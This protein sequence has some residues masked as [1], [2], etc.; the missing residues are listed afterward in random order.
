[1]SNTAPELSSDEQRAL[2]VRAELPEAEPIWGEVARVYEAFDGAWIVSAHRTGTYRTSSALRTSI[3]HWPAD[4]K[5]RLTTLVVEEN[6]LGNRWPSVD[7]KMLNRAYWGKSM[8]FGR[9]M[10]RFFQYLEF[11]SF[12]IGDYILPSQIDG[13]ADNRPSEERLMAWMEAIDKRELRGIFDALRAEGL[14]EDHLGL[15]LTAKGFARMDEVVVGGAATSQAFVAMWFGAKMDEAYEDGI[16][17]ALR[18]A[19]FTPMR[20]DRKEH[21]RKIDDEIVAEIRK[22]RFL[23]ADFTCGLVQAEGVVEAVH[24]GGV[25]FEA[26]LAQGLGM[27]VVWTVHEDM[28]EHVHLDVRQFNHVVW[29]TPEDLREKLRRRVLAVVGAGTAAVG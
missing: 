11:V 16:A 10:E 13:S 20:I 28:I 25:Y 5:A 9:K 24:R 7:Q 1:M 18:D 21:S 22:S 26:G 23:V 2:L 27:E 19:G 14:I 6:R 17:P 3:G 29:K 8:R 15:R 4:A 12:R